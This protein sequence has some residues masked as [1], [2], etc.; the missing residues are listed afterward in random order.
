LP[1]SWFNSLCNPVHHRLGD[2]NHRNYCGDLYRLV[3]SHAQRAVLINLAIRVEMGD[4]NDTREQDKRNAE[5]S[6]D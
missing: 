1:G 5:N 3:D 2:Q 4:V 6:Q